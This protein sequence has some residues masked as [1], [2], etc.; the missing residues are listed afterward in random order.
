VADAEAAAFRTRGRMQAAAAT[1][2]HCPKKLLLVE[3]LV[4]AFMRASVTE[5]FRTRGA[6]FYSTFFQELSGCAELICLAV[7]DVW[8]PK[9]CSYAVPSEFIKNVI[10][11][12]DRYIAG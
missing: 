7:F 12:D 2:A 10:T 4:V 6:E 1:S 11:P 9:S 8:S 3:P 5:G